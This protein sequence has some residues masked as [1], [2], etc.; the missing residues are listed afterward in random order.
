MLTIRQPVTVKFIL[1]EQTKQRA[2]SEFHQMISNVSNEIDSIETQ[3]KQFMEQA[4]QQ[5]EEAVQALEAK[6]QEE[7]SKREERRDQ[8]IQQLSQIQQM[9]L[10]EEVTQGQ[11][12]TSVEV[13]VGDS[14]D[15]VLLGSEIIVKDGIVVEI[16]Q[17]GDTLR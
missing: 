13:K 11:V 4:I 6:I 10:G 2:V 12:E 3:G 9:N 14:W 5:G 17:S 16:R 7:K 8:L 1:T 15:K